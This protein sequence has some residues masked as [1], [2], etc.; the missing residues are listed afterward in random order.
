[1]VKKIA[2]CVGINE[3]APHTGI[4][5]L[6][7]CVNDALLIGEMLRF[8]GFQVR[9]VHNKAATK[10]GILSRLENEI[11]RLRSGDYF[12]FWNSSHGYQLIDRSGD[13]LLDGL[14]EAICTYD[15]DVR[16]PLSDD[17]LAGVFSRA[18]PDAT[19][20]LGSDSCHSGTLT[21]STAEGLRRDET[22]DR[23]YQSPRLWVPPD[24]I[25]FRAG[26]VDFDMWTLIDEKP[27]QRQKLDI[28]G[29]NP[30]YFGRLGHPPPEVPSLLLS[31]SRADQV[32]WDAQYGGQFHGA[33]TFNF[34][35]AVLTAWRAGKSITF[36]EAHEK[37]VEG[38]RARFDQNP[39]LQGPDN[40]FKQPVFGFVPF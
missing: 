40:L 8:A 31:G 10:D 29:L 35:K 39:Q 18:N 38:V 22:S 24:D 28:S 16:N 2:L 7:G 11:A 15:T 20:F 19:V 37:T 23:L 25:R 30:R 5:N 33:M 1:M 6:R 34:A 12:V 32:S 21:R 26:Q 9:Q 13:E 27:A 17:K 14:D 4:A 3:Y 36:A